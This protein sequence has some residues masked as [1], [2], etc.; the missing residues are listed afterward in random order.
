MRGKLPR[1]YADD[2]LT[3]LGVGTIVLLLALILFRVTSVLVALTL[4]PIAAGL[5]GGFGREVGTFALDGIRGVVPVASLFAFAV[6]YFGVMNDAGLFDPIVRRLVSIA[7]SDPVKITVG[8]AAIAT[9]AHLDGAGASTFMITVPA[10]LPLYSRLRMDPLTLTCTTALAA[11]TMNILPWGG[12]TARAASALHVSTND[13]FLPVLPAMLTGLVGV[14]VLS[15]AMGRRERRRLAGLSPVADAD[16]AGE[17]V[18]AASV[19][20]RRMDARWFINFGLT[21]A[22]LAALFTSILPPAIVFIV[23]ASIALVVNYPNASRQRERITAHGSNAM[24]MVTT[25][26][27][28]GVFTGILTRSGMLGAMSTAAANMLP[29]TALRHLPIGMAV[30]SMPLSLAFDPDSF[31]FGL[32]PVL[33]NA[34]HA[35]GGSSIEVARAAVLGQMTTGF[36]VSPLTPSTFLLVGLAGVDLGDHQRRTIA[37]AFGITIIMTVAA[38]LFRAIAI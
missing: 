7:G 5:A 15:I 34:C 27:A 36:P 1:I 26:F 12:P 35:A 19:A 10:M 14:F 21:I 8:T 9:V 2:M 17:D 4:V 25:I 29:E 30:T 31:Y 32:L 28:A 3:W 22:S 11:G 18:G 13:V 16:A 6:L 37:Y 24:L 23:G 38:V 20:D 33:A